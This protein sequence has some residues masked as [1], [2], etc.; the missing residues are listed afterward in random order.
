MRIPNFLL[1]PSN[2]S[3]AVDSKGAIFQLKQDR[4]IERD[5]IDIDTQ[6][7]LEL[8]E[9]EILGPKHPSRR[10]T[11]RFKFNGEY[12]VAN[13]LADQSS[14][15][16]EIF[17][18]NEGDIYYG[19]NCTPDPDDADESGLIKLPPISGRHI[20]ALT[21]EAEAEAVEMSAL[22]YR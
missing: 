15:V 8:K 13:P 12:I 14:S 6:T 17:K 9:S 5:R 2:F 3:F 22:E 4:I 10:F 11:I 7:L 18:T 19:I 16:V 21:E 20:D 1:T